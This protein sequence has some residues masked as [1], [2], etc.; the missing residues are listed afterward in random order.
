MIEGILIIIILILCYIIYSKQPE[1]LSEL[2][3]LR[4][5]NE[6]LKLKLNENNAE[7]KD[8]EDN[9]TKIINELQSSI[10]KDRLDFEKRIGSQSQ[11]IKEVQD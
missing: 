5:E 4:N 11:H 6:F 10:T 9:L 3:D 1:D 8:R 2:D 7:S